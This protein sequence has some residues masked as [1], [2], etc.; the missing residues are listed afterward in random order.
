MTQYFY[1]HFHVKTDILGKVIGLGDGTE[2]HL[3]R[4]RLWSWKMISLYLFFHRLVL[5]S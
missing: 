5:K 3:I 2:K 4:G 1:K